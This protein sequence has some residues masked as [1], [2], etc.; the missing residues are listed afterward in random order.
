MKGKE[1]QKAICFGSLQDFKKKKLNL[2]LPTTDTIPSG[3][4]KQTNK[5][6][7]NSFEMLSN[8]VFYLFSYYKTKNLF[9]L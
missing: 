9:E 2:V 6:K 5:Q 8:Y 3:A 1:E 7:P 4:M